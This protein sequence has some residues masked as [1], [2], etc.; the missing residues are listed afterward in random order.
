MLESVSILQILSK[1][2][3]LWV[4][5][6]CVHTNMIAAKQ[7]LVLV[8]MI[9]PKVAP[10]HSVIGLNEIGKSAHCIL[11]ITQ[12]SIGKYRVS[13]KTSTETTSTAM[14]WELPVPKSAIYSPSANNLIQCSS[15]KSSAE[16]LTRKKKKKLRPLYESTNPVRYLTKLSR[17]VSASS[18]GAYIGPSWTWEVV[19]TGEVHLYRID[20]TSKCG[21]RIGA[22]V[23]LP[24][25]G[26]FEGT[27]GNMS[28]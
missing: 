18:S 24:C 1:S 26:S 17:L 9:C 20:C 16:C 14:Q 28:W 12:L 7:T 3:Y 22:S 13:I 15:M 21:S 2:G 19:K 11:P 27:L 10:R 4:Y 23:H 25:I 8:V 5:W 6:W